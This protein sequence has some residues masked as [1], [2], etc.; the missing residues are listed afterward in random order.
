[1]H[2]FSLLE[3]DSHTSCHRERFHVRAFDLLAD[4]RGCIQNISDP[5]V[6]RSEFMSHVIAA[7]FPRE[8]CTPGHESRD[9]PLW[10]R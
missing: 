6:R 10:M 2:D 8:V 7:L 1:L 3:G 5:L 9:R 4:T